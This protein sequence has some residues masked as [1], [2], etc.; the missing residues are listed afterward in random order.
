M[1]RIYFFLIVILTVLNQGVF[2]DP[3][4]ATK[5]YGLFIG[6]NNGGKERQ[7]LRYAVSD[8]K[9]VTKV[10]LEMGGIQSEDAIL[11]VEPTIRDINQQIDSISLQLVEAKKTYKRTELVFYYS[12]H[13]DEEGLLLNRERYGYKELRDKINNLP[14]D[15]RIIILDSCS[16]GAITRTKGGVKT[17]PFMIDSSNSAE[18]YAFLTSSSAD[19]VSQE[20]DLIQ[21]SYFTNS[22]V[23]GL[24]GAAD[25]I[26]DG[27]V[28]L[29][30]L[31]RFAYTETLAK[32]ETSLY[33]A[34]HPNY[35]MQ[36][37]GT[38][39]V[40]LTDLKET[41]ASLILGE[42]VTGRVSIRDSSDYLIAEITKASQKPME[43]GLEPGAYRLT[44]Q[45]GDRFFRTDITL[46]K[47]KKTP[48]AMGNFKPI[49]ATAAVARGGDDLSDE[50]QY[51]LEEARKNMN[52]ST[53]E[54]TVSQDE[55]MVY[56]L[57][58]FKFKFI[59]DSWRGRIP[60]KTTNNFLIGLISADGYNLEGVGV[61]LIGLT[62]NG[63]VQGVQASGI[64]N[65]AQS[66]DGI[67]VSYIFNNI[68]NGN[69]RGLQTSNF[70]N[71]VK[72]GRVYGAQVSYGAN[73]AYGL[74]GFQAA[75]F[76][77]VE[78]DVLGIQAGFINWTG[79][80][81]IG[82]QTG[83][84]NISGEGGDSAQIGLV[85]VS[86]NPEVIPIGLINFVK[87]GIFHPSIFMDD[88]QFF[89]FGLR[90]GS[91]HFYSMWITGVKHYDTTKSSEP[92]TGLDNSD[93]NTY[94]TARFGF[95]AELPLGPIFLNLDFLAGPMMS[96]DPYIN[97]DIKTDDEARQLI[98]DTVSVMA[99]IRLTAGFKIFE[100]LGAY[101]GISYDYF[102]RVS[103]IS[104]VP[105]TA[106][107]GEFSWS[108]DRNI[109]RMGFFA[110][111]QF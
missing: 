101:A 88:M 33:G 36:I 53:V 2:A 13:S 73:M 63:Y 92:W 30:E 85:N 104:P 96:I 39:D 111:I 18:G 98:E 81:F 51:L 68:K 83:M 45:Q 95:G 57:E 15:M 25:T 47:D 29:N 44:L 77:G 106:S 105:S 35:D 107:F 80:S 93:G 42:D 65:F 8:A 9:A 43:L 55:K 79:G 87:G 6:A 46:I 21:G 37:S 102:Y 24:R 17:K 94:V 22:L 20:S 61:G 76:N 59:Q 7:T 11:L 109:H 56:P 32:T 23:S 14:S 100:H 71:G 78:T 1:K 16:S 90:T 41:S 60:E 103:S 3:D 48:I 28:S 4:G 99:Q 62:N 75:F 91:K 12:G 50:D 82:I 34:Q 54:G 108:D 97:A 26:G 31:Y 70:Y 5:R 64:Y 52:K 69:L 38:G 74:T 67:Q 72:N 58:S 19:E 49:T 110:G 89:N 84:V 10:F 66:V 27:R 40:I 86:K